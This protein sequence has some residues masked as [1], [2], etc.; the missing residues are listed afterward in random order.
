MIFSDIVL[1]FSGR[2]NPRRIFNMEIGKTSYST[3][4][5]VVLIG[6]FILPGVDL[7]GKLFLAELNKKLECNSL[8]H[9]HLVFFN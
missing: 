1:F 2:T 7:S 8:V 3:Q 6:L 5:V 4:L 9:L